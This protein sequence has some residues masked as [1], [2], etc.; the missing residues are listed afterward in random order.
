MR[1]RHAVPVAC[2]AFSV[3]AQPLSAAPSA[4]GKPALSAADQA[5]AFKAAG[6]SR[7]GQQWQACEDPT[8]TYT[9]GAIE[10]VEDLNGDG[11]PEAVITEG[12][13]FCYGNTAAGYSVVSRQPDGAWKLITSNTG[14]PGFLANRGVG[15]WPD[16][17]VGGPGFCFPVERWDGKEYKLSRHQYE[18]KP[19]TPE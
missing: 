1:V 11:L 13:T 9:P 8:P 16:I 5:A 19:C 15:G 12:G 10:T 3:L 17:E 2:L 6:F 14:I 7:K 18:G 4:S